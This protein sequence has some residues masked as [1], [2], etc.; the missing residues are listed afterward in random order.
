V[1]E[2]SAPKGRETIYKGIRFKSRLEASVAGWLDARGGDWDYETQCF[3]AEVQDE[4][5]Q[6]LPDFRIGAEGDTGYVEVKPVTFPLWE[7]SGYAHLYPLL[8]RMQI[9]WLEEP[10]AHLAL[11]VCKFKIGPVATVT[12]RGHDHVWRYS[13]PG[14]P[15]G[16]LLLPGMGQWAAIASRHFDMVRKVGA[17]GE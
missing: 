5:V 4:H 14:I 13:G 11:W 7:A 17:V 1:V 8:A 6:Y 3:A 9:I 10:Q 15:D 2:R 12:A 16:G